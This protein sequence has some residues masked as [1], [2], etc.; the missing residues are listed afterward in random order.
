MKIKANQVFY[1]L[2]QLFSQRLELD[3]VYIIPFDNSTISGFQSPYYALG[4]SVVF[5]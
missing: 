4:A 2:G 1:H 5:S 3:W